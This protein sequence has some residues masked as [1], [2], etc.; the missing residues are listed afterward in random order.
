MS[1]QFTKRGPKLGRR[2]SNWEDAA[3]VRGSSGSGNPLHG[4]FA[5]E[6]HTQ[7]AR[8]MRQCL[9]SL[10][11]LALPLLAAAFL[12]PSATLPGQAGTSKASWPS[13]ASKHRLPLR[14][15]QGTRLI[16]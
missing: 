4:S 10:V 7:R 12:S 8:N 2:C 11:L 13:A 9:S 3:L 14:S 5:E 16:F 6:I 1:T 15:Y